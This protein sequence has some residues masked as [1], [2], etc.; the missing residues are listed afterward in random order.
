M[1]VEGV[2]G[3]ARVDF[4]TQIGRPLRQR[5]VAVYFARNLLAV[6]QH[7][8]GEHI[9][10]HEITV[11]ACI[12]A[13]T[14]TRPRHACMRNRR[15]QPLVRQRIAG[16]P[17]KALKAV[18]RIRPVILL[19]APQVDNRAQHRLPVRVKNLRPPRR[20]PVEIAQLDWIA[21]GVDLVFALPHPR[22]ALG[23][24]HFPTLTVGLAIKRIGIRINAHVHHLAR[25]EP[26]DN[27]LHVGI[28]SGQRHVVAHLSR[29]V[30]QPHRRNVSGKY[31]ARAILN[32]FGRRL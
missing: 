31:V 32:Q 7:H 2:R 12:V 22:V 29:R 20:L 11:G 15:A 28:P 19:Y 16:R 6:S 9:G 21:Q 25:N 26:F 1:L 18:R 13:R 27:A 10:R 3:N 4:C 14:K 23:L 17:A 5:L 8:D 30:A 24:V